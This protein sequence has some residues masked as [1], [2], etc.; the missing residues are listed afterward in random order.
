[1]QKTSPFQ[2]GIAELV[3]GETR[4]LTLQFASVPCASQPLP[5]WGLRSLF[6]VKRGISCSSLLRLC[7]AT[8]ANLGIAS[9]LVLLAMTEG[10]VIASL[11]LLSLRAFFYCHCE[12]KAWQSHNPSYRSRH[13]LF[14]PLTSSTFFC[15]GPAFSCFSLE[16]ALCA[17]SQTS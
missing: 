9:S 11:F 3:P 10:G 17:S 12:P 15:L 13:S 4:N 8:A 6:R 5:T 16:I 7:L 2:L 1:M 14:I